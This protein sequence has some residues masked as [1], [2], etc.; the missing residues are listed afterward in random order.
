LA[1][2]YH[3][4]V[5]RDDPQAEE[6]FK[7]ISEAYAVLSDTDRRA[8]YDRFGHG[9]Q[10][11][12]GFGRGAVDIFDIFASAFGGDPFG[13][14]GAAGRQVRVGRDLR[15]EMRIALEDVLTG[16]DEQIEYERFAACEACDGTGAE[17]GTVVKPCPTCGGVGQVQATHNTFFGTMSTVQECPQCHG[18]G[19]FV[20][21]PCSECHGQ[22]VVRRKEQVS[23]SVP[24]GVNDGDELLVR[25]FGEAPQ[26]G[27][28]TGDLYVRV[29]IQEH[30]RFARKGSDLLAELEL[31][32][33]QATLGDTV[34]F[35]G[36]DGP[37]E[38]Q[39]PAGTQNGT[40]LEFEGRG[41]PRIQSNRR[42][43]LR[44]RTHVVVPT[45]LSPRQREVL[46][47][48]AAERGE[49]VCP[50]D[51]SLFERIRDAITGQ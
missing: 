10:G 29:H 33:A 11:D 26:G 50:E 36:M 2:K 23:I 13:F 19:E 38:V 15:Y 45:D 28:R 41:L 25:G 22:A 7:E 39:I 37:V 27:G 35:E 42:G 1:R 44:L 6:V 34:S 30:E 8:K 47:A 12:P 43:S 9:A 14:G 4:D 21:R 40:L 49:D 16:I 51:R 46:M 32:V 18:S 20:D 3:P 31:T 5:K 48:F 17:P 24:A